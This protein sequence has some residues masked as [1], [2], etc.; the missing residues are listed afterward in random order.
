MKNTREFITLVNGMKHDALVRMFPVAERSF[1]RTQ[2]RETLVV[3]AITERNTF[4]REA[5]ADYLAARAARKIEAAKVAY[6]NP[7]FI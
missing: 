1:R 5:L 7:T 4:R 2:D 3:Q 6:E